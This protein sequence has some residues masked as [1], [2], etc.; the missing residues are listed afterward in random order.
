[1]MTKYD[2]VEKI[3]DHT[4]P[5][6]VLETCTA[7]LNEEYTITLKRFCDNELQ[8]LVQYP[9]GEE[10]LISLTVSETAGYTLMCFCIDT[11]RG[12]FCQHV[13]AL[14][15]RAI[16]V[17]SAKEIRVIAR[18]AERSIQSQPK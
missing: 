17:F 8:G 16:G 18:A 1:M 9:A 5:A 13:V 7:L 6:S 11:Y 10:K 2:L 4:R 14:A 15:M 12:Y 3:M